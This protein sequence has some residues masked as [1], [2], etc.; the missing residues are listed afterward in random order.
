LVN[1]DVLLHHLLL[2]PMASC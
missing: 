1:V 2:P